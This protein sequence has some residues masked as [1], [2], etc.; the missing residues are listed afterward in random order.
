MYFYIKNFLIKDL[1]V[2]SYIIGKLP[3]IAK[4]YTAWI[5]NTNFKS[6]S[7]HDDYETIN[8]NTD[9]SNFK[10]DIFPSVEFSLKGL[11]KRENSCYR[12]CNKIEKS[13]NSENYNATCGENFIIFLLNLT[14]SNLII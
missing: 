3:A 2:E 7:L 9:W 14:L 13:R 1:H 10:K 11:L 8:L 4:E 5:L 6:P 12:R